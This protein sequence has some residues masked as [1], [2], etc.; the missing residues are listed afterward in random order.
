MDI[1]VYIPTHGL[2]RINEEKNNFYLQRIDPADVKPVQFAQEA[3]RQGFHSVWFSDHVVMGKDLGTDYPASGSGESCYLRQPVMFD[4]VAVMGALAATTTKIKFATAVHI[5]PYRHPLISAHQFAAIDYMSEGRLMVGVGIGWESF[6]FD[7]LKADRPHRATITE[8][9]LQI[10]KQAW[11]KDFIDFDGEHFQIH[12]V[13]TDPKPWQDPHPPLLYGTHTAPG[14]KRAVRLA[15]GIYMASHLDPFPTIDVRP[16]QEAALREAERSGRDLSTFWWGTVA[17]SHI[18][19]PDGPDAKRERRP[20]LAGSKDQILEEMQE[21]ADLGF[22]H[23]TIHFDIRSNTNEELYEQLAR[24]GEEII[25]EANK[26]V[27]A[28]V[29]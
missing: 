20:I 9:S 26:M 1:G 11:T 16:A 27:A 2:C 23:L 4:A 6:E 5:V 29:Q 12:D 25:P 28:P 19:D 7:A 21:L 18:C 10:Y 13:S 14:A 8:E 24:Y 3:E 17:S 22:G 15:D